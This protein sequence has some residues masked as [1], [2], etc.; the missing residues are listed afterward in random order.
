MCTSLYSRKSDRT[1]RRHKKIKRDLEAQGFLS[2]PE[3]FKRKAEATR[4]QEGIRAT[5]R[6]HGGGGGGGGGGRGG[7][8]R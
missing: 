5:Q 1:I 7:G 8:G 4:Q 2:L 6:F 3:F